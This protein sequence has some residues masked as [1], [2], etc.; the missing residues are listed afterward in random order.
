MHCLDFDLNVLARL[1]V[2]CSSLGKLISTLI[3]SAL[4]ELY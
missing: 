3:F 4:I 2:F 1:Q